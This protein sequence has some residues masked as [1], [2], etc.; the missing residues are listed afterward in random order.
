M[1]QRQ[2]IMLLT[3]AKSLKLISNAMKEAISISRN[4]RRRIT[5]LGQIKFTSRLQCNMQNICTTC[6]HTTKIKYFVPLE[7]QAMYTVFN[8]N[9]N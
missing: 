3:D 1:P 6:G 2:N 5:K 8:N 7:L 9:L 4:T